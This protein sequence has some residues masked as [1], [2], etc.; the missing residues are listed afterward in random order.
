MGCSIISKSTLKTHC[1][2]SIKVNLKSETQQKSI[3]IYAS[4]YRTQAKFA[5]NLQKHKSQLMV[6]YEVPIDKEA[7]PW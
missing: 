5:K 3:S 7:S 4:N 2:E 6:I 1:P